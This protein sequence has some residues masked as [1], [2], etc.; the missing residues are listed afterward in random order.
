VSEPHRLIP[1]TVNAPA[2]GT[3]RWSGAFQSRFFLALLLGFVW[4]GPAWWNHRVLAALPAWD[5]VVILAWLIDFR[6]LPPPEAIQVSR[7][8]SEPPSLNLDSQV[9]LLV[10]NNSGRALEVHIEDNLPATLCGKL[11]RF[12]LTLHPRGI[13]RANY[14][15]HPTMRGDLQVGRVFVRYH[16][17]VRFAERWATAELSQTVRIFPNLR[18]PERFTLYLVRGR[19][20]EQE[21]R[22]KRLI[23]RGREFE[24]L[25]EY[26]ESDEIRDISWPATA[27]HRKLISKVYEV[28]RSQSV[29]LMVD[30]G[31]LMLA[32]TRPPHSP[33]ELFSKASSEVKSE[34]GISTPLMKLDY[35]V[36]A[37]LSLAHVALHSGDTTGL[38]TYGRKLQSFLPAARSPG[39]LRHIVEQLALVSGESVEANHALAADSLMTRH[40]RRSLVVWITDLAETAATPE[41]IEAASRLLPRHLVLFAVVGEPELR[42]LVGRRPDTPARMYQY[43]AAQEI[44]Q[45]RE[46]LLRRMREQGALAMEFLPGRLSS[47]LVNHY[48]Q[49]KSRGML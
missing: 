42:E 43:V 39:H 32:R 49:I 25:R 40:C 35:A 13:A 47:N 18:E 26:R 27:R 22:L 10:E 16:S 5:G 8:W 24:S 36:N 14:W 21:K 4:I 29:F 45:R 3:R 30:A 33:G 19:Q 15:I 41:V 44:I 48:L 37:A 11:P 1:T 38:V 20:I 9:E 7:R 17:P 46:I 2:R 23:G 12:T 31:R 6:R 34:Q 28:E